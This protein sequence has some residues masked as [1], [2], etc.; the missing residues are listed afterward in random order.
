VQ[1]NFRTELETDIIYKRDF[2]EHYKHRKMSLY[3]IHIIHLHLQDLNI[4][5]KC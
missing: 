2:S 4:S 5:N 1:S 3:V